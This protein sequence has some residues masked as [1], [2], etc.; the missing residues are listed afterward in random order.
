MPH[1]ALAQGVYEITVVII[2]YLG[3]DKV[4]ES[5]KKSAFAEQRLNAVKLAVKSL[6]PFGDLHFINSAHHGNGREAFAQFGNVVACGNLK[7]HHK[8]NACLGKKGYQLVADAVCINS[9]DGYIMF[10]CKLN[11]AAVIR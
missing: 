3:W 6:S 11:D 9:D 2:G 4:V 7:R 5:R 10:F 1:Y 8:I